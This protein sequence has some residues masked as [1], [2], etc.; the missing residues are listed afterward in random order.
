MGGFLKA[1]LCGAFHMHDP[2]PKWQVETTDRVIISTSCRRCGRQM[3]LGRWGSWM[4]PEEV[5][6][7]RGRERTKGLLR[8]T[9]GA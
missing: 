9:S 3:R 8:D 1:L 5:G 7:D 2:D 4:E 6:Y